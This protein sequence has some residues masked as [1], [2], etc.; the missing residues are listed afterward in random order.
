MGIS[1]LNINI[2]DES[3]FGNLVTVIELKKGT[4]NTRLLSTKK[5]PEFCVPIFSE[6]IA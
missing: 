1:L 5:N 6:A 4:Q 2:A 3:G